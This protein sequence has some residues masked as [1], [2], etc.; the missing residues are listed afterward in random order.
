MSSL[1]PTTYAERSANTATNNTTQL[2]I[3]MQQKLFLILLSSL[4]SII[5]NEPIKPHRRTENPHPIPSHSPACWSRPFPSA[6]ATGIQRRTA[7]LSPICGPHPLP[8]A[9]APGL[10][11]ECTVLKIAHPY[12]SAERLILYHNS[13]LTAHR[14]R[15]LRDPAHAQLWH[16]S[17]QELWSPTFTPLLPELSCRQCR[18]SQKL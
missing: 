13:P 3:S 11:P 17:H 8:T 18:V 2:L 10:P 1:G 16:Y 12:C 5:T 4:L 7:L 14:F 9:G 15:R 6:G